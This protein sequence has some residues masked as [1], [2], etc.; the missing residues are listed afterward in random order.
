MKEGQLVYRRDYSNRGRNKI[1]DV[2]SLTKYKVIQAPM[3]GG[4]VYSIALTNT[5]ARV[6]RLHR[7]MLKPVPDVFPLYPSP[8]VGPESLGFEN[9]GRDPGHTESV[10][11]LLHPDGWQEIL[12][13]V[14]DRLPFAST[15]ASDSGLISLRRWARETAGRHGSPH[16][17]PRAVGSSARGLRLLSLVK[18]Q[19]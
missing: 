4:T 9:V 7:T 15:E 1:Q 8:Y 18:V 12:G 16:H 17:L 2:W 6:K 10:D 19:G 5:L 11:G 14:A 13:Q 3:E